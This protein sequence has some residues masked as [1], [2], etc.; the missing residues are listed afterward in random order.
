MLNV[1]W[2]KEMLDGTFANTLFTNQSP[3]NSIKC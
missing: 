1:R 3:Q 2:K